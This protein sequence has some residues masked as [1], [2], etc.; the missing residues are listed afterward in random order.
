[1]LT[2]SS[3][4]IWQKKSKKIDLDFSKL[5][6]DIIDL[7]DND[8]ANALRKEQAPWMNIMIEQLSFQIALN[9][10]V[11]NRTLLVQELQTRTLPGN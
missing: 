6:Y 5:Q 10:S 2:S 9:N 8:D 11:W 1:M 3:Y 7:I 4:N